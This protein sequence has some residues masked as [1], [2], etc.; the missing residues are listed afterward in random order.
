MPAT[1]KRRTTRAE[2]G[3]LLADFYESFEDKTF[4]GHDFMGEG[5]DLDEFGSSSDEDDKEESIAIKK[6]TQTNIQEES[7][8]T[9]E[10]MDVVEENEQQKL[11]RKQKFNNLD[12]VL[13]EMNYD[14]LSQQ[15]EGR[16]NSGEKE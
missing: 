16:E 12:E 8:D 15:K 7:V 4:P 2:Q 5:E 10:A 9:P 3:K 1:K 11:P 6:D 14:K 13:N